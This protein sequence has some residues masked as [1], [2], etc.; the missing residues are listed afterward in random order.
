MERLPKDVIN[1]LKRTDRYKNMII[2]DTPVVFKEYFKDKNYDLVQLFDTTPIE[3]AGKVID[4]VGFC[5]VCSWLYSKL[6]P[7][8]QD[9]YNHKMTVYGYKEWSNEDK[10]IRQAIDILVGDDW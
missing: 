5:G 4:I 10:G 6:R 3:N 8:D 7:L 9:I 1:L 2:L